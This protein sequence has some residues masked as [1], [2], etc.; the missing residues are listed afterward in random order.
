MVDS[1]LISPNRLDYMM[2]DMARSD[3]PFASVS[4]FL[5]KGV[6]CSKMSSTFDPTKNTARRHRIARL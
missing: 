1:G 5:L 6:D 3:H 4:C 2:A